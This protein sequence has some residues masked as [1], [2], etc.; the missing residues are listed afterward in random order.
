LA[1]LRQGL[2]LTVRR[3]RFFINLL[4][5]RLKH[6]PRVDFGSSLLVRAKRTIYDAKRPLPLQRP[7]CF[8]LGMAGQ[9]DYQF[10]QMAS[11]KSGAN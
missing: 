3:G 6:Q 10:D 9:F 11:E 8:V 2:G 4:R 7:F 5:L 1:L